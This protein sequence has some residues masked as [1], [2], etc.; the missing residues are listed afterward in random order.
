MNSPTPHKS[1]AVR[2]I[3]HEI[4]ETTLLSLLLYLVISTL[5]GRFE[6]HQI[7]MEPNLHEGQRVIVSRLES[8]LSPLLAKTVYAADKDHAMLLRPRRGQVIVFNPLDGGTIPLIKRVIGVPGDTLEIAK[9]AVWV[10]GKRLEEPY[11]HSLSTSCSRYCGPMTLG[12]DM[13][14]VMGDNRPNSQD[15]R[16]FGPVTGDRVIGRVIM[17]YWPLNKIEFY[18]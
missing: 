5:I 17:R 4:V 3:F 15:S 6:I 14:F 2:S 1:T 8:L 9:G 11:V 13:Y 7:S 18:P 10:N 16:S 12:S